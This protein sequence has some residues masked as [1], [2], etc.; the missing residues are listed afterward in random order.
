MSKGIFSTE[1]PS[2]REGAANVIRGALQK[3]YFVILVAV[4]QM[5][6]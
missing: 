4:Q 1:I 6:N 2:I 3:E 5:L